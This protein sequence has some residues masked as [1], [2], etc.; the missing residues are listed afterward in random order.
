MK[1]LLEKIGKEAKC[2]LGGLLVTVIVL[3]VK[4]SYGKTRYLI[5]PIAGSGEIWVEGLNFK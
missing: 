3:D 2:K 1:E 5:T 4:V